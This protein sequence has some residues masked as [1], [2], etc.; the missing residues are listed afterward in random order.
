MCDVKNT[1]RPGGYLGRAGGAV[2]YRLPMD[3]ATAESVEIEHRHLRSAIE[4]AVL[5]AAEGQKRRPPLPYPAELRAFFSK[6]R[7]P[8]GSLGRLRRAIEA[9]PTFRERI[10][11]GALPELVDEVGRLWL[12]RPS[13]W[14]DDARRIISATTAAVESGDLRATAARA[15]KRR[16]AAEQATARARAEV[17][18]LEAQV[19]TQRDEIEQLRTDLIKADESLA[20]MRAELID[21][22]NEIRHARDREAAA[23]AK[24]E[25]ALAARDEA[26]V[27]L[28]EAAAVRD[29]GLA[30]RAE[31]R[32]Q[33]AELGAAAAAARRLADQLDDLLPREPDGDGGRRVR[34][35][36]RAPLSLPG[37]VISTSAD[38]AEF[39]VRSD[40]AMLVDG[41]NVSKLGWPALGLEAQR[42]T[43]LD[44]LE[45]LVSRFGTDIT[46]VFDG[47][48]VV[49]AHTDRR[50]LVRVV[51][52]RAGVIADDV[53]RDEVRRLPLARPVA[54]V[55]NDAEIVRDVRA[56]G[57]N[58]VPSNA[59][60]ALF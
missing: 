36:R 5:I 6:P 40:A 47:A 3:G 34:P 18:R 41:Y 17:V 22:R 49:G 29:G 9:D 58:T 46:V 50:R 33:A 24:L 38:A 53:I 54:V 45:N 60:I 26:R 39:F 31:T 44:A 10:A 15:D 51:Y 23:T 37:G 28:A 2:R 25:S 27:E 56:L 1:S 13:G 14:D 8:S 11:L 48:D 20:E 21:V 19:A 57:A 7:I 59:L 30:D 42:A 12:E 52:S 4:F 43:L 16:V 35:D 55:T 32:Q